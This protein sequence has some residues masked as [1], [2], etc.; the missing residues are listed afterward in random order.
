VLHKLISASI[1]M[2]AATAAPPPPGELVGLGGRR[3]HLNCA[4]A[5]TPAVIVENGGGGFSVEWA[6]V[7]PVIAKHTRICTYDRDL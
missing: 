5:G 7:Q 2:F 4:G 1:L 3:L 6:L